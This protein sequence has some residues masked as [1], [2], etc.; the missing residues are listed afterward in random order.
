MSVG[1]SRSAAASSDSREDRAQLSCI[2]RVSHAVWLVYGL[3]IVTDVERD[4][5]IG[6]LRLLHGYLLT[7]PG[8]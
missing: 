8:V 5:Q 7:I 3:S 1:Q 4:T 2:G 6:T